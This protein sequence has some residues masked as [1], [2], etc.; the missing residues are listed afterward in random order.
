[1]MTAKSFNYIVKTLT[2]KSYSYWDSI[3]KHAGDHVIAVDHTEVLL[4]R[5]RHSV[6]YVVK[7]KWPG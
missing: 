4:G 7:N 5:D 6:L 1:M 2:E 3:D